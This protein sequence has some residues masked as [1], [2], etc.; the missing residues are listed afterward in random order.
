MR[1][2]D[3]VIST[4]GPPMDDF[5]M[6][7][8]NPAAS[9]SGRLVQYHVLWSLL[10]VGTVLAFDGICSWHASAF[11]GWVPDPKEWMWIAVGLLL[12][13]AFVAGA[14]A[15]LLG[16]LSYFGI[17]RK[18]RRQLVCGSPLVMMGMVSVGI[19]Y[20]YSGT[21]G[22]VLAGLCWFAVLLVIAP[23]IFGESGRRPRSRRS[24]WRCSVSEMAEAANAH[25]CS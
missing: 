11:T 9:E 15:E 7:E 10:L 13:V 18:H 20:S 2:L 17:T 6:S 4:C 14:I 23:I 25:R 22:C 19:G 5:Q 1:K 21:W 24:G 16:R 3:A 8:Q 12:L